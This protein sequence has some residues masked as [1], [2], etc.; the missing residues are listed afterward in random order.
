[1]LEAMG[2]FISYLVRTA[3]ITV[4]LYG[5]ISMVLIYLVARDGALALKENAVVVALWIIPIASAIIAIGSDKAA[6][7]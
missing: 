1:M 6:P 5:G 7:K 4:V 2:G 3:K